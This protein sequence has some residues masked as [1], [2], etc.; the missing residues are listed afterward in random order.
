MRLWKPRRK[1]ATYSQLVAQANEHAVIHDAEETVGAAWMAGLLEAERQAATARRVC[2][3]MR[4]TA[5]D[6][7]RSAKA[8]RDSEQL[9]ESYHEL[10]ASQQAL[11]RVRDR[12]DGLRHFAER[13]RAAWVEAERM[14]ALEVLADREQLEQAGQELR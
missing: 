3:H 7:Y 5:H 10:A 8:G 14:R 6:I 12:Q 9:A 2:T 11:A 4:D 13:E 1:Q